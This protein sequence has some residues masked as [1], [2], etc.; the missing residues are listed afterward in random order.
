MSFETSTGRSYTIG[1]PLSTDD[2]DALADDV[3]TFNPMF[4]EKVEVDMEMIKYAA[5]RHSTFF[6][7]ESMKDFSD[8]TFALAAVPPKQQQDNESVYTL[9]RGIIVQRL[10]EIRQLKKNIDGISDSFKEWVSN[11]G[12]ERTD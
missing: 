11:S 8:R 9:S 5:Q 7:P 4:S 10:T 1:V 12:S 6:V 2:F 3:K